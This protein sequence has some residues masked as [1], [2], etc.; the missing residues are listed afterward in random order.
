MDL[1]GICS[2]WQQLLLLIATSMLIG[3]SKTG[4]Q[5]ITLAAIPLMSMAFGAKESTGIMLPLL[6][7]A[8]LVAVAVYRRRASWK[9]IR[10]LLP[11][12]VAGFVLA[13]AVD[14][15]VPPQDFRYLMGC[16]LLSVLVFMAW[17]RLRRQESSW[18]EKPWF[19]AACGLMGGFTTMIGNAAGPVMAIFLL[20]AKAPKYVFIGTNAWF[21]LCVNY[22]KIP[23]QVFAWNNISI[24]TIMLDACMFPA[25]GI[26]AFAGI[27]LVRVLPEELFRKVTFALTCI[28]VGAM[29]L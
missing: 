2:S 29:F 11:F 12:A 6:C 9:Y 24:N 7:A 4:L 1:F 17:N 15:A 19:A 28:A 25:V 26:G 13:L 3:M 5:G 21:F 20:S 8:D 16:C 10:R 27:R 18:A 23:L 22:L 14:R